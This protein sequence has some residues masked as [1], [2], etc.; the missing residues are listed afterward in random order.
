MSVLGWSLTLTT[1]LG[2][3][4]AEVETISSER[5]AGELLELNDQGVS[6]KIGD[7]T[8]V[9]PATQVLEIRRALPPVPLPQAPGSNCLMAPASRA[10]TSASSAIGPP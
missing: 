2:A 9:I 10:K 7:E 1:L 3:V 4:P 8:R 5:L 6:L